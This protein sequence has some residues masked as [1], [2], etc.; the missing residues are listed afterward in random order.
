M[1]FYAK[2]KRLSLTPIS[3]SIPNGMEFYLSKL[4]RAPD[5][6]G[7]QFP[8][9]WNSTR[10]R[11]ARHLFLG[12]SIPNGMEFYSKPNPALGI[13]QE[14]QF[15]TG[16]NSTNSLPHIGCEQ[17]FQFPTGWNST[18]AFTSYIFKISSFNS[19]RDGILL[20]RALRKL[21]A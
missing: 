11:L 12:V 5:F 4:Q 15:P 6:G 14:F 13:S 21:L 9:G 8:T 18:V 10:P 19:Q 1:E 16:W 3:V 20:Y 17:W 7:F 2:P